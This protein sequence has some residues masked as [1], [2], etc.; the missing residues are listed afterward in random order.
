MCIIILPRRISMPSLNLRHLVV[1]ER[2]HAKKQRYQWP[3]HPSTHP[4]R[5]LCVP[6]PQ[7]SLR[8]YAHTDPTQSTKSDEINWSE[9]DGG[10]LSTFV[11]QINV[12]LSTGETAAVHGRR[13]L[14]NS[15]VLD[16][17]ESVKQ[18]WT[19]KVVINITSWR[20]RMNKHP[21]G[22]EARLAWKCLFTPT[23]LAG[24]FNWW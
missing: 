14:K 18:W 6:R 21:M 5:S 22:C 13:D 16:W 20:T 24:D 12:M 19:V 7:L 8:K 23:L 3:S 17:S 1:F 10:Q 9:K 2:L 11:I 15:Q 4:S